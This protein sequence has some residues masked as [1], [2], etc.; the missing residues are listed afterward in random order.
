MSWFSDLSSALGIP[1]GGA[2]VASAIYFV[3][4]A[5]ENEARKEA[6]ADIAHVLEDPSWSQ[7]FQPNTIIGNM[8][9]W[10]F[11]ERQLSWKCVRRSALATVL[12]CAFFAIVAYGA[13]ATPMVKLNEPADYVILTLLFLLCSL[14]PD[15]LA[16]AKTRIL[17]ARLHARTHVS[18]IALMVLLDIALSMLISCLVAVITI[19]VVLRRGV[20]AAV[21]LVEGSLLSLRESSDSFPAFDIFFASTLMTSIWLL[22]ILLASGLLKLILPL[23]YVRRFVTWFFPVDQHPVRA[24]GIVSAAFVWFGS[25]IIAMLSRWAA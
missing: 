6:L 17:I 25:L 24:I 22:M 7:G 3:S 18:A 9:R 8:F 19:V 20:V 14:I 23:E 12:F 1:A 4:V 16:L 10:T 11:G 13:G 15:Y 5:A 2:A 21:E